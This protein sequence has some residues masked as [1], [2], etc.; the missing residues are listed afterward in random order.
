MIGAVL[1]LLLPILAGGV[2]YALR[3]W[4]GLPAL[5][6]AAIS[7][8]LGGALVLLPL[9]RPITLL[10]REIM[11]GGE[12]ELLGR[13]L[14]LGPQAQPVLAFLFLTGGFLFLFAWRLEPEGLLAP[15]GLALL[16]L[17]SGVL[18]ARP[19]IY[20]ALLLQIAAT[21]SVFPL[22]ASPRAPVQAGLRY[23]TFCT[24][25]LPGLLIS[26]WLLDI[27]A[28][29]PDPPLLSTATAL[30]GFSFALLLGAVPFH[31]WVPA[32]G[33]YGEPLASAFIFSISS[34]AV[35]FL[36]MAYLQT[37]P[38][39]AGYARWTTTLMTIGVVTA[40]TGGLL[41][42]ARRG[43]GALMGYAVMVDSG[44]L[45]VMLGQATRT[46]V[47]LGNTAVFA[48]A[49]GVVLMAAGLMGLREQSGGEIWKPEGMGRKAPWST[50]AFLVGGLSLAGFPPTAGFAPRWGIY[51]LLFR[52]RPWVSLLLL[53]A[54]AG[55]VV[56]LLRLLHELLSR[57][58]RLRGE[59][60]EK[61]P[62]PPTEPE[63]KLLTVLLIIGLIGVI[64]LGIFPQGLA[65]AAAQAG[66]GFILPGP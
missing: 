63:P 55:V 3:R 43:P 34:S 7:F 36:L 17:L 38:W 42:T 49:P 4:R 57:P 48:R 58:P 35:W 21:L 31:P 44:V 40:V 60:G 27:Y 64:G 5:L 8:A 15:L 28:V 52:T 50:V 23:L 11:L 56:G 24:L 10:G 46:G 66:A 65:A 33:R 1:L 32:V 37:Y 18:L 41:A 19:L 13:T 22:Q 30:I 54:S 59:E 51:Y 47:T 29:T 45:L 16:G 6:A 26:H 9:D 20:S 39:L 25:A 53:L 14:S 61:E 12:A 62:P 2:T